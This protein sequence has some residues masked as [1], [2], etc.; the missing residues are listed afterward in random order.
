ME[1]KTNCPWCNELVALTEGA[2]D[3]SY[4]TVVEKRCPKCGSLVS[5]R[6]KGIPEAI[7]KKNIGV[8]A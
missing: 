6:L 7:T 1:E 3:G 8:K 4:G 5:A 2:Y